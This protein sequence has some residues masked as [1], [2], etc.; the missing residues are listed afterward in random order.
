MGREQPLRV[1][2]AANEEWGLNFAHDVV[3]GG[4][5]IRVLS[6]V[7]ACSQE[8]LALDVA[9]S[10]TTR[11]VMRVLEQ[12]ISECGQPLAIRCDNRPE[13]K[14]R[15]FIAWCV[16]RQIDLRKSTQNEHLESL[17]GR[18]RSECLAVNWF[19]DLFDARRKVAAW[20]IN[21]NEECLHGG[22]GYQ[23][24]KEFGAQVE[25]RYGTDG[26]GGPKDWPLPR[27]RPRSK[28]NNFTVSFRGQVGT[29]IRNEEED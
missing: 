27:S 25:Q 24:P 3:A 21:H 22:W 4:Q 1:C 14:S 12:V 7:D 13:L 19:E 28:P 17:Q 10:F 2:T 20:R 9:T 23:T 18:L 6:V 11:R 8:C 29:R 15:R 5:A 26:T 16:E